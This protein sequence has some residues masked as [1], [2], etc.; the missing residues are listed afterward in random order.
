[1]GPLYDCVAFG[2][3]AYT[4][5]AFRVRTLGPKRF[6]LQPGTLIVSTHRRETDAPL[7]CP[8]LYFRAE[9][10]RNRPERMSFS[11]RDD[12]FLPGFFAGFPPNL[13]PR[14]RRLLFP[15]NAGRMLPRVQVHPIRSA[16]V[17]RLGEVLRERPETPLAELVPGGIE[18]RF[19][20][21]SAE[22]GLPRPVRAAEV[23]SGEYADLLWQAVAPADVASGL[24]KFWARRAAQA[25]SDFRDLVDLVRKGG[26]LLVFP[27]GRPSPDGEIGPFRRGLSALVRRARPSWILPLA[28]AYDPLVRGRT[29][30]FVSIGEA[31]E[32][33]E[34]EAEAE[35]LA[36]LRR[37]TPLTCGQFVASRLL[38]GG[39]PSEDELAEE[40]EAALR[41]RRPIDQEL[42]GDEG[43]RRRLAEALA[44]A[45]RRENELPFLAR[46]YRSARA[47]T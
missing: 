19:R 30:A 10:W 41:E 6:R 11:A 4:N 28:L 36:L 12:M 14:M 2:M 21:R 47:A 45:A 24:E 37:T 3:W 43:R 1:M 35:I 39:N 32:P 7:I 20:A 5:A 13:S 29:L 33:P 42:T 26:S 40:V 16:N 38:D 18:S 27:E 46:E 9:L 8:P 22:R 25:A 17:A 44:V 31:V 15:I 23:L 34:Q